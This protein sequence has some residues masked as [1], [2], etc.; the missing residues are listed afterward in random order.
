MSVCEASC[1]GVKMCMAPATTRVFF[2]DGAHGRNERKTVTPSPS[3]RNFMAALDLV[4]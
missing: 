1:G 2:S 3:R 4:G